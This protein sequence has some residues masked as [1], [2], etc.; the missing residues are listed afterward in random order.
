LEAREKKDAMLQ[1][2]SQVK[3]AESLA[4]ATKR[5]AER[6]NKVAEDAQISAAT[7]VSMQDQNQKQSSLTIS[8]NHTPQ[9]HDM[10]MQVYDNP[11]VTGIDYS[12]P[13]G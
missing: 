8:T 7:A 11:S 13:F 5:E 12:N 1:A 6:L 3:D 9:R 4:M 10:P 2:Q